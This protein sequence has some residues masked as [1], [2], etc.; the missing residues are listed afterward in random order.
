M[1]DESKIKEQEIVD[2]I[3]DKYKSLESPDFSFVEQIVSTNPYAEITQYYKQIGFFLEED[4]DTNDDVSFGYLLKKE[5]KQWI[6]RLSMVG[7]YAVLLELDDPINPQLV[8]VVSRVK[9]PLSNLEQQIVTVLEEHGIE[10]MTQ[11]ILSIPIALSLFN[12]DLENTRIYQALFTDTDVLP[13]EE[14]K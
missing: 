13:W 3:C 4:T 11:D 5:N 14:C 9:Y 12:T 10:L 6:L 2:S 1:L 8:K 7:S